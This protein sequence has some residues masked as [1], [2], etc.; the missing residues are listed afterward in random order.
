MGPKPHEKSPIQLSELLH[1]LESWRPPGSQP[2][3]AVKPQLRNVAAV[4]AGMPRGTFLSAIKF[5]SRH[6]GR[7]EKNSFHFKSFKK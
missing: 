7:S 3:S 1:A 4:S 2:S 5:T 6:A